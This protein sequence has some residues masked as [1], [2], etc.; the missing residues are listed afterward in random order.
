[1]ILYFGSEMIFKII[2]DVVGFCWV[3]LAYWS[4]WYEWL[5]LFSVVL[6]SNLFVH[7]FI[8]INLSIIYCCCECCF[9]VRK[10][11]AHLIKALKMKN[12]QQ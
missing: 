10:T 3:G 7:N 12:C 5:L 8:V 6:I 9:A 11:V 1:M 4:C 2:F